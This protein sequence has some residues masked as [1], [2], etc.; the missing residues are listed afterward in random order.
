MN[1]QAM[2][3]GGIAIAISTLLAWLVS[4]FGGVQIPAE[5]SAALATIVGFLIGWRTPTTP[6]MFEE[7]EQ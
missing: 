1:N 2:T 4:E 6:T 7:Q 5:V 3:N